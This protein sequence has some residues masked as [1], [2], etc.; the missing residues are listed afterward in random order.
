MNGY[1]SP[2]YKNNRIT[3]ISSRKYAFSMGIIRILSLILVFSFWF[4]EMR[5]GING[6]VY[7]KVSL[8]YIERVG[9]PWV[10]E[11]IIILMALVFVLGV[12]S[13]ELHLRSIWSTR[14]ALLMC[15]VSLLVIPISLLFGLQAGEAAFGHLR[16]TLESLVLFIIESHVAWQTRDLYLIVWLFIGGTVFN[17]I[18]AILAIYLPQWVPLPIN[19][20]PQIEYAQVAGLFSQPSR[21]SLFLAMGIALLAALFVQQ[22]LRR[23]SFRKTVFYTSLIGIL[24]IGV[25]LAQIRTSYVSIPI[26]LLVIAWLSR[27]K[28]SG[29]LG[30]SF[31]GFLIML[32][33]I[34]ILISTD[35]LP[36]ATQRMGLY[37][38]REEFALTRGLVWSIALQVI[39]RYPLGTGYDT[40]D[41]I[42]QSITGRRISH[43]H[44]L[45]LHWTVMFG[46]PGLALLIYFIARMYRETNKLMANTE[47]KGREVLFAMQSAIT[48]FLLN[49][50]TEPYFITNSGIWFWLFCGVLLSFP[51]G[52]YKKPLQSCGQHF[53]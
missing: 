2:F 34:F 6:L 49:G 21:Q 31:M 39:L 53:G 37:P 20:I 47:I 3:N 33:I 4:P 28:L 16:F 50:M 46:L 1:I 5:I 43:A 24:S 35:L 13:K 10:S 44:N 15:Y 40:I 30:R 45:F 29:R 48:V 41:A 32:I 12:L 19:L 27:N 18:V 25:G 51:T 38:F 11:L 14:I 52:A 26:T 36:V 7:P 17:A 8:Y 42:S 23:L 9:L 22:P